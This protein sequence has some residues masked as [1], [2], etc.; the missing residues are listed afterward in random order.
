MTLPGSP[1]VRQGLLSDYVE[2]SQVQSGFQVSAPYLP[3]PMG[4]K[5]D[6]KGTPSQAEAL[7]VWLFQL[8]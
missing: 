4:S 1:K 3:G 6:H 8:L 2:A 5:L 7:L